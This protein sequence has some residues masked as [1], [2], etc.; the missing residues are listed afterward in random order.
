VGK[1][2]EAQ[3]DRIGP[4]RVTPLADVVA[5]ALDGLASEDVLRAEMGRIRRRHS[6]G[7]ARAADRRRYCDCW[8][9]LALSRSRRCSSLD[10]EVA[11]QLIR[12]ADLM[13]DIRHERARR[14]VD[15]VFQTTPEH[16]TPGPE[17]PRADA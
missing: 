4:D 12:R 15:A 5:A 8:R 10:A 9:I 11:E 1:I 2:E 17:R 6:E 13:D 3:V 14:A 16:E 7:R